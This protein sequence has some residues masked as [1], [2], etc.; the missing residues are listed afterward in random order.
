MSVDGAKRTALSRGNRVRLFIFKLSLRN[1][2]FGCAFM[3][4]KVVLPV[5]CPRT[6][7]TLAKQQRRCSKWQR[8]PPIPLLLPGLLKLPLVS[9]T[10]L[11]SYPPPASVKAP[12]VPTE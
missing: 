1:G 6:V 2:I 7:T 10:K 5:P 8:P 12:D 4:Q 9:K 11:E 3:R